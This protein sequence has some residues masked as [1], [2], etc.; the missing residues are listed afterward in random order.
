MKMYHSVCRAIRDMNWLAEAT[1]TGEAL[2]FALNNTISLM[3][4]D[5][6]VVLVLTDGRADIKRDTFPLTT[7]CGKGVQVSA[8]CLVNGCLTALL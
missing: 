5:N 8:V 1:Y 4:K 7:L 3:R 6:K 2:S